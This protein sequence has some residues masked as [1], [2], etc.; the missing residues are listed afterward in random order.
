MYIIVKQR[1]F[2]TTPTH[3]KTNQESGERYLRALIPY[4]SERRLRKSSFVLLKHSL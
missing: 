1:N 2:K 3:T 4:L